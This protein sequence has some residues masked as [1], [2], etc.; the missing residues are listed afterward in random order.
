MRSCLIYQRFSNI[1][2]PEDDPGFPRFIL[3]DLVVVA[4]EIKDE[5]EDI[6]CCHQE[7]QDPLG[8][9]EYFAWFVLF[10][11]FI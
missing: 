3:L 11:D 5:V 9:L 7:D 6:S 10:L 8:L 4:D 2:I 1:N